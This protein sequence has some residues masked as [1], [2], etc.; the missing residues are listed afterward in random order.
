[1]SNICDLVKQVLET[2]Y[3]TVEAE[4]RLRRLLKRHYSEEE[5]DAFIQLQRAAMLGQVKQQ[6]REVSLC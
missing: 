1:M 3:L 5:F 4:D 2:G 6:S